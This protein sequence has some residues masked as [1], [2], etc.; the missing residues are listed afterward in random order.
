[1]A[2]RLRRVLRRTVR[3][4]RAFSLS[5]WERGSICASDNAV[6]LDH[7][8]VRAIGSLEVRHI[9]KPG[10]FPDFRDVAQVF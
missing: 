5:L 3:A 8:A 7:A 4:Q 6:A 9:K 2:D 10:P 1:M